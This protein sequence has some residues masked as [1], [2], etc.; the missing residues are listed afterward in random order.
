MDTPKTYTIDE[1]SQIFLLT[2]L[3][4]ENGIFVENQGEIDMAKRLKQQVTINGEEHWVTGLNLGDLLENYRK[5]LTKEVFEANQN[6]ASSIL[7]GDYMTKFVKTYKS[8]QATTTM[9]NR[10]RIMKNHILP[11]FGNTPIDQITTGDIQQWFNELAGT[12]SKETIKKIK[13]LMGPVFDGAVEDGHIPRN[14]LHS[15]RLKIGGRETVHHKALPPDK[16][17]AVRDRI[18]SMDLRERRMAALLCCTGMRIEEVLGLRWEDI[19]TERGCI[20][21]RRAVVHPG[22]NMPEIKSTKSKTERTIPL[23]HHLLDELSPKEE[24]GF[25]LNSYTDLSRETPLS[26]TEAAKSFKRIQKQCGVEGYTAH[27]F[28]DTCATE[29]RE[30]GISIDLIARLL[31]HKKTDVTEQRYVKY[32]PELFS[33]IKDKMD[34]YGINNGT[35]TQR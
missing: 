32:R 27:D 7:F 34:V 23:P 33:Q 14:P 5:L 22:R 16:I 19:D 1:V 24:T 35:N 20:H 4:L 15:S 2:A 18:P 11:K 17:K 6:G 30:S 9:V 8:A 12:Y 21:I 26:Y 25:L 13:A 10:D 29:W 3:L 31:G 28:R